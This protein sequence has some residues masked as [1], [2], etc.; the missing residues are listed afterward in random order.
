M[1]LL[2]DKASLNVVIL[3]W[4]LLNI[5]FGSPSEKMHAHPRSHMLLPYAFNYSNFVPK[6]DKL[7][8][9]RNLKQLQ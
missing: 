1:T 6:L 9:N 7:N 5:V 4:Y 3:M 2:L 8:I